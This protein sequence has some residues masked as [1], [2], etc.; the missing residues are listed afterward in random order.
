MYL[1]IYAYIHNDTV[2]MHYYIAYTLVCIFM[3]GV[4]SRNAM[5][6]G[7][8]EVTSKCKVWWLFFMEYELKQ[9]QIQG[10]TAG[11]E[12]ERKTL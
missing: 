1:L 5:R 11:M 2:W 7:P 3:Y 6:C 8:G 12:R 9:K 10:K 4:K